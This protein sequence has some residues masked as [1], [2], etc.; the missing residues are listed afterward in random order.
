M[1]QDKCLL[2]FYLQL[3]K[4]LDLHHLLA[5]EHLLKALR[6]SA[7]VELMAHINKPLAKD[8]L[9]DIDKF[10]ASSPAFV[11]LDD[12]EKRA[13]NTRFAVSFSSYIT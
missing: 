9:L 1:I 3:K 11:C 12:K 4:V 10:G 5:P 13:S 7:L 6:H 2:F 8:Q